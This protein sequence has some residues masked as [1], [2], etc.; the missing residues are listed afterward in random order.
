MKEIA[1]RAIEELNQ[2]YKPAFIVLYGSIPRGDFTEDSDIDVACFCES[3]SVSKDAST[4][5]G[6][7]LDCW[8]Y[9][10]DDIDPT[11]KGFLRFVGGE[12]YLDANGTGVEFLAKLTKFF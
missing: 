6:K 10:L 11:K 5:E 8:L 12:I 4:F 2:K 3:P 1:L 9:S 7:K